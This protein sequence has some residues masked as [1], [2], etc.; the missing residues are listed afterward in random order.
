MNKTSKFF[1]AFAAVALISAC[2]SE[3]PVV[4]GGE[5]GGVANGQKAYLAVTIN[6]TGDMGRGTDYTDNES[7]EDGAD[8]EHTVNNARFFFFDEN[9]NY[10]LKAEVLN[11]AFSEDNPADENIE[12]IGSKNILVLEDLTA[13]N[14]PTYMLTVLN[15]PGLSVEGKTTLNDFTTAIAQYSSD[16]EQPNTGNFVMSTTAYFTD[17]AVA[18][19]DNAYY[20]VTKLEDGDFKTTAADAQADGG[21]VEVYVERLAAKVQLDI[22]AD[23]ITLADGTVLYELEQTVAGGDN[24]DSG[25]NNSQANTKLYLKFNGWGLNATAQESYIG[26]QLKSE[27]AATAPFSA[28]QNPGYFRSFWAYSQ[29]YSMGANVEDVLEYTTVTKLAGSKL[30]SMDNDYANYCY[31]NTNE[32]A[33]IFATLSNGV[34]AVN[35]ARATHVVLYTSICDKDGNECPMINF[36]GTAYLEGSFKNYVL[37]ALKNSNRLNYYYKVADNGTEKDYL[38]I[39]PDDI[40]FE[41]IANTVGKVEI[42]LA[43]ASKDVYRKTVV[44]G[45]DTWVKLESS[46]A[47]ADELKNFRASNDINWYNNGANIYYIPVE[48]NANA[49]TKEKEGYYGVV[50]NHWYKMTVSSFSR[51]GHAVYD[52]DGGSEILKPEEPEDPLYYVGAK[53]NILSWRVISQNVEL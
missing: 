42:V 26:K 2:S 50:R 44:D 33:N 5:E 49:D 10:V 53:I 48:H 4:N 52:P 47:L 11:P 6:S 45:K 39:T 14:Y 12:Y 17:G 37:N 34:K 43:D 8:A 20:N 36:R 40:T 38:Q 16:F 25:N 9:G 30:I 21:A 22:D 1:A 41:G 3:E 28:W 29:P 51:L 35:S 15:M 27:W 24:N 18:N 46:K 7:Y 13:K 19:H 32:A 31:E 23:H